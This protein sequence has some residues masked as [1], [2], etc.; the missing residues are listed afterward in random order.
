[1]N[2]SNLNCL[3]CEKNKL[4][5]LNFE[6]CN[7]KICQSCLKQVLLNSTFLQKKIKPN[8]EIPCK[9][10]SSILLLTPN[11]LL[12]F[13]QSNSK[14][15]N[16]CEKHNLPFEHYCSNCRLWL[17][18]ECKKDFHNDYFSSHPLKTFNQ[19]DEN[20]NNLCPIHNNCNLS[21]YCKTCKCSICQK[22]VYNEHREHWKISFDD[23][24]KQFKKFEKK[25]KRKNLNDFTIYI[26]SCFKKTVNDIEN[27]FNLVKEKIENIIENFKKFEINLTNIKSNKII[28]IKTYIDILKNLY[29]FYYKRKEKKEKN[30]NDIK[31][32]YKAF[33]EFKE[34]TIDSKIFKQNFQK[35]D[36]YFNELFNIDFFPIKLSFYYH[37]N[38]NIFKKEKYTHCSKSI[39]I[40]EKWVNCIVEINDDK[41]AAG[42]GDFLIK[43]KKVIKIFNLMS[44][45]EEGKLIGHTN[46]IISLIYLKN[47]GKLISGSLDNSIKIWNL[48]TYKE[49]KTLY[50]HLGN[51]QCLLELNNNTL[52]SGSGDSTIKFWNLFNYSNI[53]TLKGHKDKIRAMIKLK[54]GRI[55]SGSYDNTIKVWNL[56]NEKEDF[57]LSDKVDDVF[58]LIQLFNGNLASGSK[59]NKIKIWDLKKGIIQYFLIGHT[60]CVL[61]LIN[62]KD[63]RLVSCG[64]D[65]KIKIWRVDNRREEITLEGHNDI[66]NC[67]IQLGNGK[68]VSCSLDRTIKFWN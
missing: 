36:S 8:F 40:Q 17:C 38:K 55:A 32:L 54:D 45:K 65:K 44:Y 66:V 51:V 21:Y 1:M 31:F 63:G 30:R 60:D 10:N 61:C 22:G 57:T 2:E 12:S 37:D 59:D 27:S 15:D 39:S 43:G 23:Y 4:I 42:C 20:D 11:S 26:D 49:E 33:T 48:N 52:V 28:E 34:I 9:C 19:F 46:D 35:I 3:L 47:N 25:W 58:C 18:S 64:S 24:M 68:I 67:L 62:L 53:K 14:I 5:Y 29:N 7:H 56:S 16:I 13:L 50:G 41:L 6:K